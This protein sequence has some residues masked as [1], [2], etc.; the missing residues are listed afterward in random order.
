[1]RILK[2]EPLFSEKVLL[3]YKGHKKKINI[4]VDYNLNIQG[5]QEAVSE[6]SAAAS[7]LDIEDYD[8]TYVRLQDAVKKLFQCAFG[9]ETADEIFSFFDG[10]AIAMASAFTPYIT[11]VINP[12]LEKASLRRAKADR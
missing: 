4:S 10:D 11:G 2:H 6:M 8:A 12:K 5:I 7:A 9:R 3:V 1:M